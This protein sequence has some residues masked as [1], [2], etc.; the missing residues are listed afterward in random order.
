MPV[1]EEDSGDAAAEVVAVEAVEEGAAARAIL[2]RIVRL[3]EG[4]WMNRIFRRVG[5][6]SCLQREQRWRAEVR[7]MTRMRAAVAE[8][9]AVRQDLSLG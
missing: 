4:R 8:V 6:C 7:M 3:V 2:V 5:R 9:E 1:A